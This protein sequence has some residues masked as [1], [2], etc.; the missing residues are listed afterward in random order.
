VFV[1]ALAEDLQVMGR[2]ME[3]PYLFVFPVISTLAAVVLAFSVRY[4]RDELPFPMVI[5]IFLSAFGTLAILSAHARLHDRQLQS[6]QGQSRV[7]ARALLKLS[8]AAWQTATDQVG[9]PDRQT[10]IIPTIASQVAD[11][12]D[13]P[14]LSDPKPRYAP[15]KPMWRADDPP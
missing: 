4:R 1:Y 2:W 15:L 5:L 7:H 9:A 14:Y 13:R 12:G 11:I 3:R 6:L 10:T 8:A